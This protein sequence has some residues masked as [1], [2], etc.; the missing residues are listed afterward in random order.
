MY[1]KEEHKFLSVSKNV[2]RQVNS[3]QKT[4][5]FEIRYSFFH[6]RLEMYLKEDYHFL[7]LFK[8]C[9]PTSTSVP[10]AFSV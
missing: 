10:K 1:V 9:I 2:S 5:V 4:Q 7:S 3:C 6:Q 8:N